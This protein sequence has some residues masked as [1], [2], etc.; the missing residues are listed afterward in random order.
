MKTDVYGLAAAPLLPLALIAVLPAPAGESPLA[1]ALAWLLLMAVAGLPA[2]GLDAVL[3]RR[4]RDWPLKAVEPITRES[5]LSTRW[6]L[7]PWLGLAAA[8]GLAALIAAGFRHV[9]PAA[10]PTLAMMIPPAGVLLMTGLAWFAADRLVALAGG[11]AVLAAGAALALNPPDLQGLT[12]SAAGWRHAALLALIASGA[13]LG[14]TAWLARRSGSGEG[15]MGRVAGFW[16]VQT[17]SGVLAILAP[18]A[19]GTGLAPCLAAVPAAGAVL[20]L[21][22]VVAAQLQSRGNN[23]IVAVAGTGGATAA[24]TFAATAPV[25]AAAVQALALL[26]LAALAVLVGWM[27]KISYV[28]KALGVTREGGYN[29]WRVAVRLVVPL[30]CVWALTGIWR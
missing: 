8:L 20:L 5:D 21:V 7:V 24:L 3:V 10:Q 29:L 19:L 14:Q 1:L 13:S 9:A 16:L 23:K 28:R 27:M 26:A 17:L 15:L 6:R 22:Q 12:L 4:G 25:Y 2:A 30:L 11:L 18:A